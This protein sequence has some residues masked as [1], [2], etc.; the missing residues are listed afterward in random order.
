MSSLPTDPKAAE[1]P[2]EEFLNR[3]AF[4][5]KREGGTINIVDTTASERITITHKSG[6]NIKLT[7]KA[8][9]SFAPNTRQA[10]TWGSN[11]TTV[12]GDS[13]ET[14]KKS[15]E[16]R[17]FGN[18]SV[19]TGSRNF[20]TDDIATQY[21]DTMRDIAIAK[22]AP[23]AGKGIG[24]NT[25]AER[26]PGTD[27]DMDAI[28]IEKSKDL[29]DIEMR[30]GEGGNINLL[31]SK[32]LLLVAGGAAFNYDT[33]NTINEGKLVTLGNRTT[34]NNAYEPIQGY[35]PVYEDNDT[36]SAS[37]FGDIS[38]NA[39]NKINMQTGSGG[40]SLQTSGE[41][42]ISTTGRL[43]LGGKNIT[44]GSNA[45]G[46]SGKIHLQTDNDIYLRSGEKTAITSP[47][48]FIKADSNM[49]IQSPITTIIGDFH[50]HGDV[51]VHG[52]IFCTGNIE[53]LG[54]AKVHKDI[55]TLQDLR[56]AGSITA[57]GSY[58]SGGDGIIANKNIRTTEDV[59]A[60][61]IS[62]QGH[63]HPGDGS[64]AGNTGTPIP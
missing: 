60:G 40:F 36:S 32:H 55:D 49:G 21:V 12:N 64:G 54:W 34:G 7:N 15:R 52:N 61:T 51:Q 27:A 41:A 17:T 56:A 9:S 16:N 10:L 37:P 18:F 33:G 13:F 39:S 3:D 42:K 62:L 29:S 50:V 26:E 4:T 30:M 6:A 38:V 57:I 44:I 23:N 46:S 43:S 11:Y 53:V 5:V 45:D 59:I 31:S 8:Y 58:G 20:F 19:I 14:V 22:N 63:E 24:N 1:N 48:T 2:M 28:I 47:Q 25:G 35:V